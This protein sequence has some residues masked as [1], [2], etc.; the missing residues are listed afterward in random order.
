MPKRTNDFQRIVFLIQKILGDRAVVQESALL[1]DRETGS[2]VEVDILIRGDIAGTAV[3]IG[4][5]CVDRS[6]PSDIEWIRSM[7]KKHEDLPIDKSIFVSNAGF[8]RQAIAKAKANGAE[9]LTFEEVESHDW[10]GELK[11]NPNLKIASYQLSILS[12]SVHFK[13]NISTDILKSV[14]QDTLVFNKSISSGIKLSEY[15]SAVIRRNDV[16]EESIQHWLKLP[17]EKRGKS[18]IFDLK[19]IPDVSTSAEINGERYFINSFS[20]KVKADV[21]GE[22]PVKIEVA[23]FKGQVVGYSKFQN[24]FPG[25]KNKNRNAVFTLIEK[26]GK[27]DGFLSIPNY[28]GKGDKE[29]QMKSPKQKLT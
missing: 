13:E 2:D 7:L 4:V 16:F 20:F 1:K 3:V 14:S 21:T 12:G 5:E 11:E 22:T 29:F 10:I 23:S 9:T 27:V 18:F 24:I 26:D 28:E 15:G 25:S 6:R 17:K 19:I 8:T